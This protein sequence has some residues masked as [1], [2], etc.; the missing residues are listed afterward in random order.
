MFSKYKPKP[1]YWQASHS[2]VLMHGVCG[3]IPIN[4]SGGPL[5]H[6]EQLYGRRAPREA[7]QRDHL[8]TDSLVA[9][10]LGV[11]GW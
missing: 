3:G 1:I 8:D 10:G 6:R 11:G 7:L 5:E 2:R 9:C 4:R